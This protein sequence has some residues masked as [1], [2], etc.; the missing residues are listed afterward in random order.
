MAERGG[1][2]GVRGGWIRRMLPF[3]LR[4]RGSLV[5]TFIAGLIW[6][7]VSTLVPVVERHVV[8]DVILASRAPLTPWLVL[9]FALGTVGFVAAR[10]RR[11]NSSKVML[12]VAYG[13]RGAIHRELQRLDLQAHNGMATG[14]LVSRANSDISLVLTV[15]RVLPTLTSN[16]VLMVASLGVMFAFSPLLALISLVI[17]PILVVGAYRMRTR[18]YPAT[19]DMQ[20]RTGDVAQVVDQAVTG[21]RVVKG[22]GQEQREFE[23]LAGSASDLYGSSMRAIRLSARYQPLL[24]SIPTF[25]QVGVLALGGWL[26]LNDKITVGTFLAFASYLVLLINP[27]RLIA[28]M[29][30]AAPQARAGAERI[31]ELLDT[32]PAVTDAPGARELPRLR[33]EISFENVRFGFWRSEP[34]LDG[35]DLRIAPGEVVAL[36]GASGSGKSTAAHLLL[37]FHDP[38]E[39]TVR[40]DGHDVREVTLASLRSQ[41]G[42]V[43]EE[44]FL[45]S[46]SLRDNI[47][48]G[49]PDATDA[50]VEAAARAAEAHEFITRL[51]EGYD[52][53]V[54]ER[55]LTLSGGQRQR[56]ALARALL[57]DPRILVL[58]DA[59]SAVDAKVEE[60]IHATLRRVLHR[61]T[62]LLVAHRRSTL[63]LADRIAVLDAGRV[64][65]DGT[66]AELM[67]RC[68]LYRRLLSGEGDDLEPSPGPAARAEAGDGHRPGL[69]GAFAHD[70]MLR[71]V[72][73]LPPS[74]DLPEVDIARES[75]PESRF[76]LWRFLRPYRLPLGLGLLL[77]I[78][79]A[80]AGV[81]GPYLSRDGIDQG[82]LTG[83]QRALFTAAGIFLG[84]ALVDL[85][86]SRAVTLV[87]GRTGERLMFALRIRVWAQLQR[88]AVDFYDREMAGRIMTRM[89]TDV[90]AF[91]SL[92]QDGL[93][94]AVASLFTFV[95]V[96]VAMFVMSPVLTGATALVLIPLF[97]AT[98]AFRRLSAEPYREARERIAIVNASLQ[99]SMAGVRESQAFTQENRRQR[100]FKRITRSYTDARL[101]AQRLISLYFPFVD[102]LS[103]VAAV[104]V[105]ALGYH[106]VRGHSLTPGEL[107]AFVLYVNLFFSP[108]QQLSEVFDDWQQARVSMARIR[109]LM[110]EPVATPV[111]AAPVDPGPLHG[112]IRLE[113]VRFGYPGIEE[114]ALREVDLTIEPGETVALVGATGAGKSSLVKLLARFYDPQGGRIVVDGHDLRDLDLD[115]YRRQL[116]YVP[117]ETFLFRGTVH[118]NIA[119][120]RPDASAAEVERAAR[121][122]G[123]HDLIMR[124]P[125]GYDHEIAE[126]GAT[127]SAGQRQLICLAR[128]ELVDPAILLLDE[129][130]ANLDLATEARVTRAMNSVAAGRTTVLIAH[131]LQTARHADRIVVM[132]HGRVVEDGTHDQLL[133][134]RG[135]YASLWQAA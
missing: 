43:F 10:T 62:T 112:A 34:V 46:E 59:T 92:L 47:A 22:F 58:D 87:A 27:A 24:E 1:G 126:R 104:V 131:R 41:I 63:R 106:M 116:G 14:Q 97:V 33:G 80:L 2:P 122:V 130:T 64:I 57:S 48:Y 40:V 42:M 18:L 90:S 133:R 76:T 125:G 38:Q 3:V 67:G 15:L 56:V 68:P 103:D 9:L 21:V 117:Q 99:E 6:A 60:S 52:T 89:T 114:E 127:L 17:L 73:A 53:I 54:G 5:R 124:L 61:H 69:G 8:D 105:L 16:L 75:Q 100:E 35:F 135:Q 70:D 77:V 26:A 37:R 85:A 81:A 72:S 91:S 20:Q 12:E 65:D 88:L 98:V 50:E 82:V 118:D 110:A 11:F 119:Y 84:V 123:A 109:D 128:A 30:S 108:I 102:F 74:R 49:R 66:H 111:A 96:A 29:L 51:P 25:G 4:Q 71:R 39:G 23:R 32:T 129:A 120:G 121:A 134:D 113:G 79:D 19:W 95:G 7:G 101:A 44:S 78:L 94:S 107:I 28:R 55:G 115:A 36:V 13:L 93:I 132:A 45:F 31:F 86:I 83:S